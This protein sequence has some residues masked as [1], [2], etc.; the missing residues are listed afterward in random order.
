[1]STRN[2]RINL[3]ISEEELE[4]IAL[5]MGKT[6]VSNMSEFIRQMAI[7]G[8]VVN[9]DFSELKGVVSQLKRIGNGINQIAKVANSTGTVQ[10]SDVESIEANQE[11]IWKMIKTILKK[12]SD[13]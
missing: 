7:N 8:Y 5:N 11:E 2:K 10:K 6:S 4:E 1:M 12:V 3:R 9:V 13:I